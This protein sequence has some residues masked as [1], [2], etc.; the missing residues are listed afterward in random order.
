MESLANLPEDQ[1]ILF[2]KSLLAGLCRAPFGGIPKSELDYLIFT[3]ML[4]AGHI[5]VNAPVFE[6]AQ[7]LQVTPARVKSLVY[8]HRLR[9]APAL[10]DSNEL[11]KAVS[12]A[13]IQDDGRVVLNVED[14]YWRDMLTATLK[15]KGIYLD[16]SFNRE[17]LLLSKD[18]FI[19]LLEEV[20][21]DASSD[22]RKA[23]QDKSKN[24][25]FKKLRDVVVNGVVAGGGKQAGLMTMQG[26]FTYA[27]QII[28]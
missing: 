5:S 12:V 14:R 24:R 15:S 22:L 8:S 16:T 25:T 28:G 23:F 1:K 9:T 10:L 13:G 17:R 6:T 2:A 19:R 3:A 7:I 27:S 26:L 20:F 11:A 21:P 4:D 18:D